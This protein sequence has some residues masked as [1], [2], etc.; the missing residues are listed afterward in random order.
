[1]LYIVYQ[2]SEICTLK[3]GF[4]YIVKFRHISKIIS[5]LHINMHLGASNDPAIILH[6]I[7]SCRP[8]FPIVIPPEKKMH[9]SE[10]L[11]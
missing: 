2:N 10:D 1:M 5:K 8:M 7:A 3:Y 4:K 11:T 9:G 6:T